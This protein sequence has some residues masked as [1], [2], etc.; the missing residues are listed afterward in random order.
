MDCLF[1]KSFEKTM[2]GFQKL[3][4]VTPLLITAQTSF[5]DWIKDSVSK[6]ES[7]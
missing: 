5:A 7:K 1:N 6:N 4:L 2:K 3:V